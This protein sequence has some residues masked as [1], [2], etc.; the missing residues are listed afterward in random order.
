MLHFNLFIYPKIIYKQR[1]F[2]FS[3]RYYSYFTLTMVSRD[4]AV[5]SSNYLRSKHHRG[6]WHNEAHYPAIDDHH[7]ERHRAMLELQEHLGQPGTK[8][9]EIKH[10]MGTPTKI[11]D[12]PDETLAH[13]LKRNNEHFIY[14]QHAKIWIYEWRN[15]HDYVY[16]I[17]SN[18]NK[19]LQSAWYYAFE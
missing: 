15:N 1:F 3:I 17:I 7:G 6:H 11:L 19:V 18:D 13:E 16:Y 14:P 9:D 5:A 4:M 8:T 10:F 2:R 12:Q